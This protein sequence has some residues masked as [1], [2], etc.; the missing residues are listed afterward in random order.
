[1][2][3][4]TR[5]IIEEQVAHFEEQVAHFNREAQR[6]ESY[7]P[8]AKETLDKAQGYYDNCIQ[9]AKSY[10]ASARLLQ[11]LLDEGKVS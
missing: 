3:P 7:I 5:A 11:A 4:D 2:N 9:Q 1:M 6:Y 10:R 8:K